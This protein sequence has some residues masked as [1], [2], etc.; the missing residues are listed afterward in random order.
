MQAGAV[1]KAGG[2]TLGDLLYASVDVNQPNVVPVYAQ[3]MTM[4]APSASPAPT[5]DFTPQA[6]TINAH[7][8]ALFALK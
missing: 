7:V 1:A 8:N 2:R 6:V 5:A 4:A 3:R